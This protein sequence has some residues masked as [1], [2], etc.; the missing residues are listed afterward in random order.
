[1]RK[2]IFNAGPCKLPDST[3]EN[4]SKYYKNKRRRGAGNRYEVGVENINLTIGQG[5]FVFITGS[6]PMFAIS[7]SAPLSRMDD[8]SYAQARQ[9]VID[10]AARISQEIQSVEY[11]P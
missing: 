6:K 5:E 11:R 3:L 9:L 4:V 10:Y 2:H 8:A 1:M 7:I